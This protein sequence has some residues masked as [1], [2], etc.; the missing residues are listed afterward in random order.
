MNEL[1]KLRFEHLIDLTPIER[2]ALAFVIGF[3]LALAA[4]VVSLL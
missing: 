1:P 3:E 2:A 4:A